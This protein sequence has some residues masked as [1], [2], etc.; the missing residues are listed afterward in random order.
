MLCPN[1]AR[2]HDAEDR[3]CRYCGAS[4][5]C[6]LPEETAEQIPAEPDPV[7]LPEVPV[8]PPESQ[9]IPL[10]EAPA[11]P[12][13][14]QPIPLPEA[15]ASP[16]EPEH[17]NLTAPSPAR[18]EKKGALWPPVLL[19]AVM[20]CVGLLLFF[21]LPGHTAAPSQTPWFSVE[22]GELYFH[23]DLYTG[24]S[25]LTVPETV[26]GQRVTALSDFCFSGCQRL[27]TVILPDGL[28]HIGNAAFSGCGNLRG[29][30]LPDTMETIG[31]QAFYGCGNLE[32]LRIPGAMRKIAEDAF[33]GCNGLRYIFFN[34]TAAQWQRLYSGFI[35]PY[36]EIHTSDNILIPNKRP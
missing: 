20:S 31:N 15:P 33:D 24:G 14:S 18:P 32:A 30:F 4:L 1:C 7:R 6:E 35:N 21:L 27:T 13:E 26:D 34:G 10:P 25:E 2:P 11:S 29:I 36:V 28:T 23:P 9:P 8:L 16:P 22:K 5:P 19:L 12:P 17:P 3:Y